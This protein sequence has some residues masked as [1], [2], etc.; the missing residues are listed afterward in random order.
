M[1]TFIACNITLAFV[2]HQP[3]ANENQCFVEFAP[4][5][6]TTFSGGGRFISKALGGASR[7]L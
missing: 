2:R 5:R 6:V 4:S 7:G 3:S 1:P